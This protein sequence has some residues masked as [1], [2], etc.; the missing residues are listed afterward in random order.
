MAEYLEGNPPGATAESTDSKNDIESLQETPGRLVQPLETSSFDSWIKYYRRDE[1]SVNTAISYYTK[2]AVA[3]FLMDA[4]VRQAT[5]GAKS[6]DD[7]MR[8]AYTR[9]SGEKGYTPAEFRATVSEVA[10]TDLAAFFVRLL[11]STDELDYSEALAWYGL[12]FKPVGAPTRRRTRTPARR[13]SRPRP[14]SA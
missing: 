7:A 10:G 13:R 6:L 11:E 3:G 9:Y 1:N 14:G 8:L 12:R 2:G 5:D 4:K